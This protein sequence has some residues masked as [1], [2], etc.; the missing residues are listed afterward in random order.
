MIRTVEIITEV[1]PLTAA[2]C[3]GLPYSPALLLGS[4]LD[5]SITDDPEFRRACAWGFDTYF[6]EMYQWDE[7]RENL[8]FVARTYTWDE[9]IEGVVRGTLFEDLPGCL[10]SAACRAGGVLGW[11]SAHALVNRSD[12]VLALAVLRSLIVR[13]CEASCE[14]AAASWLAVS[15]DKKTR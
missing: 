14:D 7:S 6:D 15:N 12:A 8:V 2:D 10:V 9:V 13:P 5:A 3:S 1:S 11:L 4:K